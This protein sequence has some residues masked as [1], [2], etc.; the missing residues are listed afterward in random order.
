[1][2][3]KHLC[4]CNIGD[5]TY[6]AGMLFGH[7]GMARKVLVCKIIGVQYIADPHYQII[8]VRTPETPR[9][10]ACARLPSIS[11]QTEKMAVKTNK[12]AGKIA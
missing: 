8:G 7:T 3:L 12:C 11:H 6:L 5:K 4:R 10:D 9:I 2:Q 1:M